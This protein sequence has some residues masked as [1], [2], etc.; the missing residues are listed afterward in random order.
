[1]LGVTEKKGHQASTLEK[2]MHSLFKSFDLKITSE[3]NIK[4]TDFLDAI[5]NLETGT[6]SP[7]RKPLDQAIYVNRLSSH[8]PKILK[9][10]PSMVQD[11][12]SKLSSSQVE[13]DAAK[14]T[15]EDALK[16]AGYDDKLNYKPNL[17]SRRS[18]NRSR[19]TLWFNPPFSLT[20][21]SNIT[22]M[23]SKIIATSFPKD[24]EFL[25]TLFNR[26]NLKLSYCTTSNLQSILSQH[27][28][29]V[30]REYKDKNTNAQQPCNCRNKKECPMDGHCCEESLVYRA[31]VTAS[32]V[33]SES[34]F[35][36]GATGDTFKKR[37]GNHKKSFSHERYKEETT[38]SI[39]I[40]ELKEK[41][42][43]YN[44]KWTTVRRVRAHKP[45]D[46]ECALCLTEK[47]AILQYSGDARCLNKR[48][49]LLNKCRHRR[50]NLLSSVK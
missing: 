40:W 39:Y 30:I 45:G 8:P 50:K 18:K 24:H 36:L 34:F 32:G 6:T 3:I 31:D 14:T 41:G 4:S 15:Y 26:H 25:A 2:K 37:F 10:I 20:V 43:S 38:L 17:G 9:Q 21:K 27:N 35:Y 49:E 11:R 19:H 13:F 1:M 47:I 7:F 28:S 42:A 33:V 12:L 22:K 46:R 16:L 48:S 5:F 44:I 23:F 29:K